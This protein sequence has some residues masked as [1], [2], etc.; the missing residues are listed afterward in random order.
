MWK[1]L[2]L[3]FVDVEKFTIDVMVQVGQAQLPCKLEFISENDFA[4]V[5]FVYKRKSFVT[6]KHI[7]MIDALQELR[8]KLSEYGYVLRICGAC[9]YFQS[10]NDGTKNMLKGCCNCTKPS[11]TLQP[12]KETLVW[13]SCSEFSPS[14]KLNVYNDVR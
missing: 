10:T 6:Q 13:N 9:E 11:I 5:K 1:N 14:Q 3:T 8:V 7:R 4:K 12:V 2:R